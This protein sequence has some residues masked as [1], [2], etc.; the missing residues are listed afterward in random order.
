MKYLTILTKTFKS[1]IAYVSAL[2]GN[3]AANALAFFIQYSLWKTLIGT[4][5]HMGSTLD[6][7]VGYLMLTTIIRALSSS[8]LEHEIETQMQDGSISMH[9]IRPVAFRLQYLSSILGDSLFWTLTQVLPVVLVGGLLVGFPNPASAQAALFCVA[10]ALLGMMIRFE[11]GYLAG[12]S[13][14]WLQKTWYIGYFIDAGLTILGGSIVPLWFFPEGL[15][16]ASYFFPFRY[17]SFEAVNLYLGKVSGQAAL[18]SLLG[19]VLWFL[20]LYLA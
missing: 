4:G 14:F 11:I 18:Y 12:L 10:S 13:A 7:L 19:S 2:W 3:L 17:I 9:F 1:S 16:Q 5:V 20:G 15:A 8:W 6:D